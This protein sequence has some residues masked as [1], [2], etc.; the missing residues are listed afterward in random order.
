MKQVLTIFAA[1]AIGAVAAAP[2]NAAET[3]FDRPSANGYDGHYDSDRE[4]S[5]G[6]YDNGGRFNAPMPPIKTNPSGEGGGV[7]NPHL[8]PDI[9]GSAPTE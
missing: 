6:V 4:P 2:T 3:Y 5:T 7:Q 9:N 1:A 8:G